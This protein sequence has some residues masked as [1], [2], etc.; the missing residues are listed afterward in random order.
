M[1]RRLTIALSIV[2]ASILFAPVAAAIPI[3]RCHSSDGLASTNGDDANSQPV[4]AVTTPMAAPARIFATATVCQACRRVTI[5]TSSPAAAA[6][7]NAIGKCTS[8]G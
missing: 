2:A 3:H 7:T 5:T 8:S 1:F 6:N 4:I